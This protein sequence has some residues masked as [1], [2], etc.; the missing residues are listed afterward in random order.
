MHMHIYTYVYMYVHMCMCICMYTYM[1]VY[2]Q[3]CI[4]IYIY[5]C[6]YVLNGTTS[7][8]ALR[9]ILPQLS[10]SVLLTVLC[11]LSSTNITCPHKH[12]HIHTHTN[13]HKYRSKKTH[14][15]GFLYHEFDLRNWHNF[16]GVPFPCVQSYK[17]DSPPGEGFPFNQHT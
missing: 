2:I 1:Y 17:K 8:A 9:I 13:S 6:V 14:R 12:T 7:A 4:Y 3:I 11:G 5:I 16:S 15:R 10:T